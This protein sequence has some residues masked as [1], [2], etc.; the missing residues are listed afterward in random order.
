MTTFTNTHGVL[1]RIDPDIEPWFKL[2]S[3]I[4]PPNVDKATFSSQLYDRGR[5]SIMMEYPGGGIG[6]AVDVQ[7]PATRTANIQAA[8]DKLHGHCWSSWETDKQLAAVTK[9][10][11][12][13]EN[14]EFKARTLELFAT[15][16]DMKD[17]FVI[18]FTEATAMILGG[19]LVELEFRGAG[20]MVLGLWLLGRMLHAT[21]KA[22]GNHV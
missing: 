6:L 3:Y 21:L 20:L 14:F 10:Q 4:A 18:G 2:S 12:D 5:V 17:T 19:C 15:P 8:Y 7:D 16:I 9:E 1:F 11:W 22:K 13:D